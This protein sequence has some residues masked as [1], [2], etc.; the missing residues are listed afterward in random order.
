MHG[1]FVST[2]FSEFTMQ[3]PVYSSAVCIRGLVG[4]KQVSRTGTSNY[5][6]RYLWDIIT[7]PC[8]WYLHLAHTLQWRHNGH[9]C[10]S[11]HLPYHCLLSRL[12]SADQRKHQS[13]ASLASVRGIHRR[14][15]NSPHKWPVTRKM[16]PFDDVI[17]K[18][19]NV[20]RSERHF[21]AANAPGSPHRLC[22]N[23]KQK[24]AEITYKI[25]KKVR[26]IPLCFVSSNLVILKHQFNFHSNQGSAVGVKDGWSRSYLTLGVMTFNFR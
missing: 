2:H 15:V 5:I 17:M 19:S 13:S 12:F 18:T 14:P 4:Q 20:W 8:P 21:E 3:N 9:D 1:P 16:F 22:K 24:F 26:E 10:V 23:S 11:N 7:C 25:H 6:P